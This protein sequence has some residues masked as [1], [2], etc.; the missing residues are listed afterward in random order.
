MARPW[1][2]ILLGG[3]RCVA[4]CDQKNHDIAKAMTPQEFEALY[5]AVIGWI[6]QTLLSHES[7]AQ[8]VPWMGF[9]RLPLYFGRQLL[10]TTKVV[11]VDQVPPE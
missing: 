4:R 1:A 11:A 3:A 5:P 10:K 6:R 9:T 2:R 8:T 7:S